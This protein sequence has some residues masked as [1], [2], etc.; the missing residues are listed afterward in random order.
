MAPSSSEAGEGGLPPHGFLEEPFGSTQD[1]L[2]TMPKSPG[3]YARSSDMYSHMGTM[4]RQNPGK[5]GKSPGKARGTQSCREKGTPRDKMPGTTPMSGPKTPGTPDAGTDPS[6]ASGKA[7]QEEEEA[8][9]SGTPAAA[10]SRM[11]QE[12]AGIISCPRM[13]APSPRAAP[14]PAPGTETTSRDLLGKGQEH[15]SEGSPDR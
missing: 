4:P 12:P 14:D 6:S 10:M 15:P 9:P 8:L 13:E 7:E 1:D 3:P 2:N 5:A 11:E